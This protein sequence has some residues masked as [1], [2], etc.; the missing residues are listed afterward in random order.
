MMHFCTRKATR[1]LSRWSNKHNQMASAMMASHFH[2]ST[3]NKQGKPD[4]KQLSTETDE[5]IKPYD[6]IPGSETSSLQNMIFIM[7][8]FKYITQKAHHAF[9]D[10][11]AVNGPVIKNNFAGLE[12]ILIS[13]PKDIE[14]LFRAEG[15]YPRRFDVMPWL[16]YRQQRNLPL[17][18]LLA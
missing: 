10:M 18:V 13:D 6:Q 4:L 7:R 14:R 11:F 8:N 16:V 9:R 12:L 1:F 2:R 3:I 15:K 17:G 5:I